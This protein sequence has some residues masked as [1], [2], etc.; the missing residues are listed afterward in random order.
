MVW[1]MGVGIVGISLQMVDIT[2][3]IFAAVHVN[4]TLKFNDAIFS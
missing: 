2:I 3:A 4:K 1:I